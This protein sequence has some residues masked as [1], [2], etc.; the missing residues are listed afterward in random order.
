MGG[1]FR[2]GDEPGGAVGSVA[3]TASATPVSAVV[4]QYPSVIVWAMDSASVMSRVARSGSVAAS[5][6]AIPASALAFD[7]SWGIK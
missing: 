2:V 7:D 3:A 6:V 1:A 4:F 5:T